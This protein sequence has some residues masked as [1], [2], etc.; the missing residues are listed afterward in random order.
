MAVEMR[1]DVIETDVHWT[2]DGV[3]VVAHDPDVSRMTNGQGMIENLTYAD[4]LK[5][6]FGYRFS[7][8]GG[9]TFPYRSKGVKIMLFSHL[10]KEFPNIR[11]NVDL[12]PKNPP[13]LRQYI[14]EIYE[15]GAEERVM[16]ASFHDPVLKMFRKHNPQ[17]A[18]SATPIEIARLLVRQ[19]LGVSSRAR[20]PYK[21]IQVPPKMYGISVVTEGLVRATH[22]R[23]AEV[24][25][26]T[27]D[28]EPTMIDLLRQGV[29]GI[30]SNRPDL[31]RS[32]V[33]TWTPTHSQEAPV[34]MLRTGNTGSNPPADPM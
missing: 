26:W 20:A 19:R 4:L 30:M 28:D 23:G 10:L 32:V 18:T 14:Q 33:D 29:D 7:P 27:I 21:A 16:T 9:E 3:I 2:K 1:A 6:D 22:R 17:L 25:V 13:S 31:A 11:V 5:L 12:K 34:K 8:D 24:H 15:A